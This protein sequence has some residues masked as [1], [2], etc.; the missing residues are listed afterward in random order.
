MSLIINVLS[1]E[2]NISDELYVFLIYLLANRAC[3]R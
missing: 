3:F 1:Y 2:Y